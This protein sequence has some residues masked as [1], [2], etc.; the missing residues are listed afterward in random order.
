MRHRLALVAVGAALGLLLAGCGA[1]S[2]ELTKAD[3]F[4]PF[5]GYVFN[6]EAGQISAGI[7]VPRLIGADRGGAAATWIGL[8][9]AIAERTQQAPFFQVGVNEDWT[10]SNPTGNH[11]YA[12]WSSTGKNFAPQVMFSVRPGDLLNVS[13]DTA[14]RRLLIT[15]TDTRDGWHRSISAQLNGGEDFDTASWHQEDVTDLATGEP[16]PYPQ[17]GVARFTSMRVDNLPP[18]MPLLDTSWMSTS[19]AYYGP[20][21]LR[22]DGFSVGPIHPSRAALEYERLAVPFDLEGYVFSSQLASWTRSTR[23]STISAACRRYERILTSDLKSLAD[24]RWPADVRPAIARLIAST[25]QTRTYLE[26]LARRTN[27]YLEQFREAEVPSNGFAIREALHMGVF[28]P[29]GIFVA[30]YVKAHA[31]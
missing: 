30:R 2:F 17:V 6:G 15:A 26:R 7:V 20:A 25:K 3:Q 28:D 24:Y 18:R 14:G 5:A 10:N 19:D 11:Y 22:D 31:G 21:P 16:F 12:F 23:A 8:R 4:G 27:S 13:I 1:S 9:G 29:S